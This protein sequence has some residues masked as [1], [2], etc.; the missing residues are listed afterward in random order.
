MSKLPFLGMTTFL[1]KEYRIRFDG[2]SI[3]VNNDEECVYQTV[4][5]GDIVKINFLEGFPPKIS[6]FEGPKEKDSHYPLWLLLAWTRRRITPNLK[7][8][9]SKIKEAYERYGDDVI[10]IG[11]SRCRLFYISKDGKYL[12]GYC[13]MSNS[14]TKL[15]VCT[16]AYLTISII[17]DIPIGWNIIYAGDVGYN[18]DPISDSIYESNLDISKEKAIEYLKTTCGISV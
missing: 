18:Y 2:R 6:P 11:D 3:Y 16:T 13:Y 8:Y 12:R 5:P 14:A 10:S 7:K 4:F 17:E 1:G 9:N 15:D